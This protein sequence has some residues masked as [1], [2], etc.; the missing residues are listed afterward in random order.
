MDRSAPSPCCVLGR[1]ARERVAVGCARTARSAARSA[2]SHRR[3]AEGV[4]GPGRAAEPR[5]EPVR[6]LLT[7]MRDHPWPCRRSVRTAARV[8]TT[9]RGLF[10]YA[11]RTRRLRISPAL[12]AGCL[13]PT[14]GQGRS[15]RCIRSRSMY[16]CPWLRCSAA[17]LAGAPTS[18]SSW[19]S[20]AC[21]SVSYAACA[22][23]TSRPCPTPACWCSARSRSRG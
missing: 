12:S 7:G 15:W 19:R 2:G 22:F 9:L 16:F 18:H 23:G 3:S 8:R 21:F 5:L 14:R 1:V 10:D 11:V 13:A 20:P 17:S 6:K 4:P